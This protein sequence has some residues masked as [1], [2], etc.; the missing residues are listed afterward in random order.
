M[1]LGLVD[2][3]GVGLIPYSDVFLFQIYNNQWE[4]TK[5][6]VYKRRSPTNY[7]L[8]HFLPP[9]QTSSSYKKSRCKKLATAFQRSKG[10][11]NPR[12]AFDVYTLSRRASSTTRASLP[13]VDPVKTVANIIHFSGSTKVFT[14]IVSHFYDNRPNYPLIIFTESTLSST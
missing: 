10:D 4:Y 3:R 11:S 5:G 8:I 7:R 1:L 13:R 2:Q 9:Q 14:K 12:Y 6:R